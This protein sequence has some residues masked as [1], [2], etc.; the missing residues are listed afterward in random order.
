MPS[1]LSTSIACRIIT[2]RISAASLAIRSNTQASQL[3]SSQRPVMSQRELERER[4]L[5]PAIRNNNRARME[6]SSASYTVAPKST[7]DASRA[8]DPSSKPIGAS[9]IEAFRKMTAKQGKKRS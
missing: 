9:G 8:L 4:M 2:N 3:S 6:T 1:E 5:A 7:F